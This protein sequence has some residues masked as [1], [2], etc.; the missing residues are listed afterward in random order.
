[1]W[2]AIGIRG[3]AT[4]IGATA[5]WAMASVTGPP[6]RAATVA[7][8]GLVGAQ[9]IQTLIDSHAPLVVL[10]SVG[11]LG[12]LVVVVSTPGLSQVFGC[13]PLDPLG[14]GQGLVAAT[15]ASSLSAV[16]PGLLLRASQ[17]AQRR[18]LGG[19]PATAPERAQGHTR[20]V[21]RTL[22]GSAR[23]DQD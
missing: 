3:A 22:S 17:S 14:W 4:T 15:A 9:L 20:S 5:G 6:R 13:T 8:V 21:Q 11:S 10:T 12:A 16:A 1:M 19:E 2:R 18:W 23:A 7:L